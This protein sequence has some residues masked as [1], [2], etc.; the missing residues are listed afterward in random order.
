MPAVLKDNKQWD[1]VYQ[2][3]KALTACYQDAND[4]LDLSYMPST[5]EDIVL[6][7]EKQKC[8]YWVHIS[9]RKKSSLTDQGANGGI[10]GIE[11]RVI[12]RHSRR[13]VDICG[14]DNHEITTSTPIVTAG[15][16]A[17]SQR[18][19]VILIMLQE[20][21][22]H[23]QQER[24]K[25]SRQLESFAND[26]NDKLFHIPGGLQRIQTAMDGYVFPLSIR[27][28]LPYLGSIRMLNMNHPHM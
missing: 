19:D 27:D 13:T 10:A 4:V 15:A 21:A 12:E 6:F 24:K 5:A 18:G 7:K 3:L 11:T 17:R 8:M 16:V 26:G 9:C 1:S 25:S 2:T 22:Y 23:P 28:G 20:Y 14:M